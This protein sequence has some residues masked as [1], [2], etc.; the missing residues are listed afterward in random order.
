MNQELIDLLREMLPS[1]G[2]V[3]SRDVEVAA[4]RRKIGRAIELL[5]ASKP[6]AI[7]G[8]K[9]VPVE[10]TESMF[11][12]AREYWVSLHKGVAAWPCGEAMGIYASM[13]AASPAAPAQSVE[14]EPGKTEYG[15]WINKAKR[16][17][18][19]RFAFHREPFK[20]LCAFQQE[21]RKIVAAPQPSPTA[22]DVVP[23][24][25]NGDFHCPACGNVMKGPTSCGSCLWEAETCGYK[26]A[27]VLDERAAFEAW[28]EQNKGHSHG[29]S[30]RY[31]AIE[32]W[33]A[34]A[35]SS[36]PV[37]QTTGSWETSSIS[38]ELWQL[39]DQCGYEQFR[40][41]VTAHIKQAYQDGWTDRGKGISSVTYGDQK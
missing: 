18:D 31:A 19:Q 26:A 30:P 28:F 34:R 13:L 14:P 5:S 10:P 4:K 40:D 8:W 41:A 3:G 21:L 17:V 33:Q 20:Y 23:S 16:E 25:T 2:D 7:E 11:N 39:A 6:A 9:L 38:N 22:V 12:A 35:A 15:S 27:V 37:K 24:M 32:G 1:Y 29:W 36:Q